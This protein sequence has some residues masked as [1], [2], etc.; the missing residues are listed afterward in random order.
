[1]AQG[2]RAAIHIYFGE[3]CAGFALP[4]E[5]D[6]GEGLVDLYD[7]D[8]MNGQPRAI[9]DLTGSGNWRSEHNHRVVAS[10]LNTGFRLAIFSS[11]VFARMPSSRVKG[12]GVEVLLEIFDRTAGPSS[13]ESWNENGKS[14][15]PSFFK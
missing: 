13:S 4:C 8:V 9:E 11:V 12:P 5:K 3:I 2:H 7:V 15:H 1:M 6:A 10:G 14:A